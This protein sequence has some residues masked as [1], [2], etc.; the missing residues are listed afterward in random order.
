MYRWRSIETQSEYNRTKTLSLRFLTSSKL[1]QSREYILQRS[2][3]VSLHE[4]RLLFSQDFGDLYIRIHCI[5]DRE[6]S[7]TSEKVEKFL[8]EGLN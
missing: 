4:K 3:L 1:S 2:S 5:L 8:D 7:W 6:F